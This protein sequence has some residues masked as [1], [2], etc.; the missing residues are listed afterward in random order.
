MHA[1][2][3]SATEWFKQVLTKIKVNQ[4]FDDYYMGVDIGLQFKL[5]KISSNFK[6][7]NKEKL[8]NDYMTAK[9]VLII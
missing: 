4:N 7:I 3:S 6:Y 5:M 9:N 8:A 2:K 1:K